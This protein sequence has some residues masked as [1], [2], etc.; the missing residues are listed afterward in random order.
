MELCCLCYTSGPGHL[1]ADR[2]ICRKCRGDKSTRAVLEEV[3]L[4]EQDIVRLNAE[5]FN[6]IMAK[7]LALKSVIAKMKPDRR[8]GHLTAV[9]DDFTPLSE[10]TAQRALRQAYATGRSKSLDRRK[11]Q[12]ADFNGSPGEIEINFRP[13][14]KPVK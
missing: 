9:T 4:K 10:K 3:L 14:P 7:M 8:K 13:E 2:W 11:E 6:T 12:A 5:T 1:I